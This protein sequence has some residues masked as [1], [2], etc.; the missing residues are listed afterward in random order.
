MH[1]A[2]RAYLCTWARGFDE[3][4][5]QDDIQRGVGADLPR[6]D[7]GCRQARRRCCMEIFVI[8]A[9]TIDKNKT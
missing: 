9:L 3:V 8:F 1:T 5:W 6:L 2:E 7:T 4:Q